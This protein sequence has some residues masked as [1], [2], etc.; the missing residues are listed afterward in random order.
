MIV[1]S[2]SVNS[3][4]RGGGGTLKVEGAAVNPSVID[5]FERALRDE[6]HRVKGGGAS[7]QK[8]DDSYRWGFTES[9][10]VT[11]DAVRNDRYAGIVESIGAEPTPEAPESSAP[12]D[13]D[14]VAETSTEAVTEKVADLSAVE[15]GE[16]ATVVSETIEEPT[17]EDAA[18]G[19][20]ES[21]SPPPEAASQA[22]SDNADDGEA[23][24]SPD[25][26]QDAPEATTTTT[27][28]EVQP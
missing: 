17:D 9:I 8:T 11:G 18:T 23:P 7:E 12:A 2:V 15:D 3:N 22:P 1:R 20:A 13:D 5:E 6:S 10:T 28:S 16:P 14:E 26:V 19:D 24:E 21:E 27:T 4:P 25:D